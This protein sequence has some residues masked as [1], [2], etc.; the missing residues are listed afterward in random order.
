MLT[1][2]LLFL[3]I[4]AVLILVH[5]LGHFTVAKLFGIR[6]DEFGLGFPPKVFAKK[7]GETV[8]TLNAIPFGGFVKIFGEDAPELGDVGGLSGYDTRRS[9]Y[10]K[11][12]WIQALVLSAG[13]CMNIFFGFL[14]MSVG[15]MIGMP[16]PAHTSNFGEIQNP[17]LVVTSVLPNSPAFLGGLTS[18][19]T[20][21]KAVAGKNMVEDLTPESVSNLIERSQSPILIT[22]KRGASDPQTITITP[23]HTLVPDK[24][25]IGITME[26]IGTLK[27]SPVYAFI[28]GAITSWQLLQNIVVGLW[29]F[30]AGFF[31][32]SSHISDVSGPVG[33]ARVVGEA[34][35]ISYVYVLTLVALISFNLAVINLIPFPALDGGRLFF[36]L[37]EAIIRRRIHP[38]VANWVNGIGFA[39]LIILML[40]VTTHDIWGVL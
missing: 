4:L 29:N 19:D 16:A 33:I 25:V 26:T 38:T 34:R 28:Q 9:F 21:V 6:V 37:I 17:Q 15:Y 8:Y 30:I 5:E 24:Q 14:L 39:L 13:V 12:K 10:F 22:Y 20:I 31:T 18:G 36:V 35:A 2:I 7:I 3:L 40:V 32:F 11:P 27:L 23:S 1:T